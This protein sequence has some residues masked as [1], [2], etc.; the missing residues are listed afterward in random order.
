V[1]KLRDFIDLAR[2]CSIKKKKLVTDT[3][4]MASS[5]YCPEASLNVAR[6]AEAPHSSRSS[7]ADHTRHFFSLSPHLIN[8]WV[9]DS[10][11]Y[12]ETVCWFV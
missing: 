8:S 12:A 11:V 1:K 6:L 3:G 2:V 10:E 5:L 7:R 9:D 4:S